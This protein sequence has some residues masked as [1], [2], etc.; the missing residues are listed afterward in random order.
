VADLD[1]ERAKFEAWAWDQDYCL[2]TFTESGDYVENET[3]HAWE[4]WLAR[5]EAEGKDFVAEK[6]S[7][8]EHQTEML[9]CRMALNEVHIPQASPPKEDGE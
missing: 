9:M 1:N 3:I 8:P 2:D 5:A 6:K 4:A 7:S